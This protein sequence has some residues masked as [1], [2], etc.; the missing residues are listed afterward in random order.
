MPA[1]Q[2]V[3]THTH[4]CDPVFD[5]DREDVLGS[6][7]AVGIGAIVL[8]GENVND[9]VKNLELAR[10]HPILKPAAGLYP[11]NLD[12][13]AAD[14]V[15]AFIREHRSRLVAIGE[16]GL[17]HWVVKI[18]EGKALQEYL[19]GRFIALAHELDLPLN[20]HSRSA[21]KKAVDLLLARDARR[22]QFHAFDGKAS[23]ALPAVEAGYYFS[24]PPSVIRSR[25]KQK[26]IK[27]LPLS[28]LLLETDSPVLG[29]V[30][31]KR[32]EPSNITIAIDAV[33]DIKG[34]PKEAVIEAAAENAGALY[35]DALI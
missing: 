6:A 5:D 18:D 2:I 14:A 30:P 3:D 31:G 4:L 25:Q 7:R 29:P 9:A 17:D 16:V 24:V 8:V 27:A 19:F 21:G 13:D 33:A 35:G 28:C 15:I 34:I 22:V 20:V 10:Q 26:L 12:P 32:N 1:T 23:S 11:E